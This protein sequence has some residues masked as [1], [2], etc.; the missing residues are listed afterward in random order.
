MTP[1]VAA[2]TLSS[3]LQEQRSPSHHC[4]MRAVSIPCICSMTL[5]FFSCLLSTLLQ[6]ASI[7]ARDGLVGAPFSGSCGFHFDCSCTISLSEATSCWR[8]LICFSCSAIS[9]SFCWAWLRQN[10][11]CSLPCTGVDVAGFPAIGEVFFLTILVEVLFLV[12]FDISVRG[13]TECFSDLVRADR[14]SI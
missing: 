5:L 7:P 13:A 2:N 14:D 4:T 10:S 6:S 1:P 3:P 11:S 9:S 8:V 12:V